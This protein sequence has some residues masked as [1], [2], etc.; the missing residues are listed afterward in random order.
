MSTTTQNSDQVDAK[1]EL[2]KN[3][4]RSQTQNIANALLGAPN[5][6]LSTKCETRW[7]NKGSVAMSLRPNNLGQW[8]DFEEGKGGDIIQL[9]RHA[10]GLSFSD[11]LDWLKAYVGGNQETPSIPLIVPTVEVV[12]SVQE[13][14]SQP[15]SQSDKLQLSMGIWES[16]TPPTQTPVETYLKNRRCWNNWLA[17]GSAIR[18]HPQCPWK[19]SRIPAMTALITD[20]NTA[21]PI[22]VHRTFLMA[23]GSNKA[24]E[25]K[26]IL[27]KKSNGVVRLNVSAGGKIIIAEGIENALTASRLVSGTVLSAIDAGN[28]G[29]LPVYPGSEHVLIFSDPKEIEV[30]AAMKYAVGCELSGVA[31][32]LLKPKSDSLDLNDLAMAVPFKSEWG[33]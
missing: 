2:V 5:L 3:L 4:A 15:D 23:D 9:V 25:G 1:L 26:R 28:F 18:F 14:S 17:D 16:S 6:H 8:Y 29:K 33:I 20:I 19:N 22:G 11:A 13:T 30:K 21:E 24:P 32:T 10:L 27:G 7:G 31:W 12:P